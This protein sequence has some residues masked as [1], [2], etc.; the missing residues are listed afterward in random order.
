MKFFSI[1][2]YVAAFA[3]GSMCKDTCEVLDLLSENCPVWCNET[4]NVVKCLHTCTQ[5]DLECY[6]KC[7]ETS[8]ERTH[9]L[10]RN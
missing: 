4:E 9:K 1:L 5:E 6:M 3:H 8:A 2:A 7:V 10:K